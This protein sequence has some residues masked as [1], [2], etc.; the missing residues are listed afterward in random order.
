MAFMESVP[1]R[2]SNPYLARI[3]SQERIKLAALLPTT[4]H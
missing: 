3:A 2:N 1:G 4:A